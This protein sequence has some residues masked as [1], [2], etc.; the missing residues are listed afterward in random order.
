M[1]AKNNVVCAFA[2]FLEVVFCLLVCLE[3]FFSQLLMDVFHASGFTSEWFSPPK[4][5]LIEIF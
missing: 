5:V 1:L 4:G 2:R 3:E